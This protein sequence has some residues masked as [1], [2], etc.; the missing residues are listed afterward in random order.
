MGGEGDL[1]SRVRRMAALLDDDALAGLASRG[2]ARRAR[3]DAERDPPRILGEEGGCIH[4]LVEGCTVEIAERPAESRCSCPASGI[5][6]H[7][8]AALVH[9]AAEAAASPS[10]E[11]PAAG[12]GEELLSIGDDE[13][14]RWAGTA[15][16]KRALAEVAGGLEVACED[17]APF[18][19]RL[20]AWNAECR[21]YPGAG[22]AGMICSCHAPGA[23]SHK[24]A[25]IVAWQ[26]RGGRR[27][28][29][30]EETLLAQAEGA[31]R[32]REEVR[33]SVQ[34]TLCEVLALGVSRLSP[35]V[36]GRLRTLAT[37][38]HGVD[39]PR[40]ERLLLGVADEVS[41]SLRREA[42][43]SSGG[44]IA[45]AAQASALADALA[46]PTPALVGRHRSRYE[47]VG[48]LELTGLGARAWKSASGYAGL[49]LYF[50]DR[51]SA[52]WSTWTEARPIAAAGFDPLAR[53]AAAGPWAGCESPAVAAAGQLR[54]LGAFRNQAGRL[55][56][57]EA[58]RMLKL[59]PAATEA[60]PDV[61]RW[62]DLV[63]RAWAAFGAGLGDRDEQAEIVLLRPSAWGG[64]RFDDIQQALVVEVLDDARRR[65]TLFLPHVDGRR[66][67]ETLEQATGRPPPR[68]LATLRVRQGL[69]AAEPV[70]LVEAGGAVTSLGLSAGSR[71]IPAARPIPT[72]AVTED[73][74]G[75]GVEAPEDAEPA[76]DAPAP[77]GAAGELL[78][79]AWAELERLA[80]GG[81]AA[82][83][84]FGALGALSERAD[85]M[86]LGLVAS[87]L[88]RIRDAGLDA[89]ADAA[90][91][92]H[93]IA[94]LALRA[95]YVVRATELT[96][97]IEAATS[98][99]S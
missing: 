55:S 90:D 51:A 16:L 64:V 86:G 5:C 59:G 38:A 40:L 43:A 25:T 8:L 81:G 66:G 17:G 77:A 78:L 45:R 22:L 7:V 60:V 3:K 75:E 35:A 26:V 96:E 19:A 54:L 74:E 18:V 41:A 31:P 98:V 67:I 50:W 33:T 82:Y 28:V 34:R 92:L 2:L 84:G 29:A 48:D 12:C 73:P 93:G 57:R 85:G 1:L 23:C 58:T 15:S 70:S 72:E 30:Q 80:E 46:A 10:P 79:A 4:L 39:L 14:R 83:R 76:E 53:F 20:P 91:R 21:F 88:R 94:R 61:V 44:L 13:L 37:T 9:L 97:A 69:L 11:T 47:R 36:E 68:V 32:T 42:R 52:R 27:D 95:A 49:T 87:G 89:S 65:L 99:Y 6:R 56:G 62:S 71:A 63:P 24:L